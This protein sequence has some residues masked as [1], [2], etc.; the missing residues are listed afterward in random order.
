MCALREPIVRL[1]KKQGGIAIVNMKGVFCNSI[2]VEKAECK[3]ISAGSVQGKRKSYW[4]AAFR[5]SV[6]GFYMITAGEF[7]EVGPFRQDIS[8][9]VTSPD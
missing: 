1:R 7:L 6:S 9:P 8:C 2:Q 4:L 3:R 5:A